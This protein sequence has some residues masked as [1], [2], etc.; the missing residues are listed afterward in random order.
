M[1][2]WKRNAVVFTVILF[3]CVALYLSWSYNK[4]EG[5]DLLA[6]LDTS[7]VGQA[8]QSDVGGS[9]LILDEI[10]NPTIVDGSDAGDASPADQENTFFTEA[11]LDRQRAR[12]SAIAI[13]KENT[14]EDIT[15]QQTKD[16]ATAEIETL[17]KNVMSEARIE[18]LVKA[19]G[20][21][22]CVA[23]LNADGIRIVVEPPEGGLMAADLAKITDIVLS[24]VKLSPE[25][26]KITPSDT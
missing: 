12:D 20:F 14:G 8:G 26:I 7:E 17:A 15:D 22:D 25:Q 5:D 18:G 1:R 16:K 19:K 13:L 6:G 9:D 11:R 3:V 10:G 24:E 2:I 21:T 4:G 23:Y